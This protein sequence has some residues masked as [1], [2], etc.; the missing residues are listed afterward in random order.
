MIF[1]DFVRC[2]FELATAS[3]GDSR[4][5][6]DVPL[7][8]GHFHQRLA[9]ASA[10]KAPRNRRA[11]VVIH[12]A[13]VRL[14][15][16]SSCS[17]CSS[18]LDS[19]PQRSAYARPDGVYRIEP[20]VALEDVPTRERSHC[21]ARLFGARAVRALRLVPDKS[22]ELAR[23]R[24]GASTATD[25]DPPG[26]L[27]N[28][29]TMS[30]TGTLTAGGEQ[31]RKSEDRPLSSQPSPTAHP[32][33]ASGRAISARRDP[34]RIRRQIPRS[35][36]AYRGRSSAWKSGRSSWSSMRV[37]RGVG[38]PHPWSNADQASSG[39]ASRRT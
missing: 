39:C 31:A 32:L 1:V 11:V 33:A 24:C 26:R 19:L 20:A 28:A 38:S 22:R 2:D 29:N 13:C 6:S 34:F 3:L 15:P 12:R 36:P 30:S 16:S 18:A 23:I 17:E 14:E 25:H 7:D 10:L 8:L 9:C 21:G 5:V 4:C 27:L 37:S 35:R